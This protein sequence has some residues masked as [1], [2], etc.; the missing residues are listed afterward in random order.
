MRSS[1]VVS[2]PDRSLD[3]RVA[4]VTGANHGIGA[5]AAR[6]LA[7]QGAPVLLAYL[8]LEIDGGD[9]TPAAYG[10]QRAQ[11]GEDVAR[12]IEAAGGPAVAVEADLADPAVPAALFNAAER[13]L[14]PVEILVSVGPQMARAIEAVQCGWFPEHERMFARRPDGSAKV[15]NASAITHRWTKPKVIRCQTP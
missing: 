4:L 8:R 14:G 9:G 2:P 3:G 12:E 11:R 10:E 7:A 15:A 13:D 6:A 1:L 5:A